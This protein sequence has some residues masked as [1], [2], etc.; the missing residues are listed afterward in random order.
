MKETEA[1]DQSIAEALGPHIKD[2]DLPEMETPEYE[3]YADD[4]TPPTIIP[5]RDDYDATAFDPYL[6]AEVLADSHR[7]S[8]H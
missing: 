4:D 1:F 7:S 6:H 5:D 8:S 2:K 3:P